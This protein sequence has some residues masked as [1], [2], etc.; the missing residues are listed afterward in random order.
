[1]VFCICT[2]CFIV[3]RKEQQQQKKK[4]KKCTGVV[5]YKMKQD[6]INRFLLC[7]PLFI[8]NSLFQDW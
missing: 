6:W 4:S 8:V 5:H 2:D 3:K 1:M 7:A